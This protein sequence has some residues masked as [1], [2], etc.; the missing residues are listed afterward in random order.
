MTRLRERLAEDDLAAETV[1]RTVIDARQF[2]EWYRGTAG[3]ELDPE[4]V[5]VVNVDL[6][7]YRGWLQRHD[8]QP[9]TIQRK[10]ASLRKALMLVCPERALRLRWPKLP[11]AQAT[12][13]S[14]LTRNE[15]NAILRACEQL[16]ARDALV[17]KLAL[18]TGA[19]SSSLANLR[20]S[21]VEI[22]PR[23]GNLTFRGKGNRQY[24]TPANREVREA[25]TA[26]LA[27][28]PPVSHDFLLVQER[29][30]HGRCSRWLLHD[31]AHRRLARH[32]PAEVAKRLKGLHA[33]RHDLARRLLSGDE[34][35]RPPTP[36]AD[37]AAILGHADVRV[38]AGIYARPS[39]ED[40]RRALD[41]VVGEEEGTED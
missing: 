14:G 6:S 2:E 13:P 36:L 18:F 20:L 16:S 40:M 23:S 39:P 12:A 22:G 31:I 21:D 10:F 34:G 1:K 3:Q 11:Q 38:T 41:G 15:R 26:F 27:E 29:W 7:E 17:V 28:R 33:F 30:P 24:T 9:S 19:R 25:L 35:R 32:L 5:P 4:T 37:V 8:M